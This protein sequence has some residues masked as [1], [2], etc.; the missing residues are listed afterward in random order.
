MVN[1]SCEPERLIAIE[2]YLYAVE[3]L[4]FVLFVKFLI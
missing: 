2:L 1:L 4:F 3:N